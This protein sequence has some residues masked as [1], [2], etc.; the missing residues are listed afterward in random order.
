MEKTLFFIKPDA[1]ERNLIGE[2]IRKVEN[3]GFKINNLK[4]VRLR[5]AQAE[6]F[7]KIHKGKDFFEKLVEYVCAGLIVA[8]VLEK[9]SAIK[10]LRELVGA[11]DPAFAKK[12]SIRYDFGL[13][14]TR[15]S[16]HASDSSKTAKDEILFFFPEKD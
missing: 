9:E 4:M 11:T 3:S 12:G 15:N 10:D 8:M 16:C 13:D 2:V 5:K 7:Y 6:E 1:V 14:V